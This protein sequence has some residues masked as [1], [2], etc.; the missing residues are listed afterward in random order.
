MKS[1]SSI[2]SGGAGEST[3]E[4]DKL[5][6]DLIKQ[7]QF[8]T[9]SIQNIKELLE[10]GANPNIK[11]P[12]VNTYTTI[13]NIIKT[14][15][16]PEI[17]KLL[18][19]YG[20]DANLQDT[21]GYNNGET[22]LHFVIGLKNLDLVKL[23]IKHHALINLQD[24]N[25]E[26]P[27]FKAVYRRAIDIVNYLLENNADVD[28]L[29]YSKIYIPT[30][31]ETYI[32]ALH[33]A[34]LHNLVEITKLLIQY[35]ADDNIG[36]DKHLTPLI[37]AIVRNNIEIV[38]ILLPHCT[39][40]NLVMGLEQAFHGRKLNMVKLLV[41]HENFDLIYDNQ[42]LLLDTMK[43]I[44]EQFL[45]TFSD[46][47]LE[48]I[49]WLISYIGKHPFEVLME[50]EQDVLTELMYIYSSDVKK[51]EFLIELGAKV[52]DIHPETGDTSLIVSAKNPYTNIEI[53]KCLL[54][55]VKGSKSTFINHE[56]NQGETALILFANYSDNIIKYLIENGGDIN[57]RNQYGET[58]FMYACKSSIDIEYLIKQGAKINNQ[59]LNGETP[60]IWS[61]KDEN[62]TNV[63]I[64][65]QNDAD[66][67]LETVEHKNAFQIALEVNNS[68]ILRLISEHIMENN[69]D[70]NN[71]YYKY[72][73]KY[74]SDNRFNWKD[75]CKLKDRY[76]IQKYKDLLHIE[77]SDV[78]DVCEQLDLYET[79]LSQI[80][81]NDIGKCVNSD[82]LDGNDVNDIY[83]ENFYVY[84]ENGTTY[85]EDIR[86]LFK[87]LKSFKKRQPPKQAENPYTGKPFS[88][89]IIKDIEEKYKIY[90]T[91][92]TGKQMDEVVTPVTPSSKDILLGQMSFF[93]NI[94]KQLSSK[95][96]FLN[97]QTDKLDSFIQE[98]KDIQV[99]GNVI[100]ND[101]ELQKLKNDDDLDKYKYQLIQLLLSKVLA[102][103]YKYVE[104]EQIIFPT[105]E[106]IQTVWNKVFKLN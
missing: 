99:Y 38:K 45:Q 27:L 56:N 89:D 53:V 48:I 102:D 35:D 51:I 13:T 14:K 57:Y 24:N 36:Y 54:N 62:D 26:T 22:L 60:L 95:E 63:R 72:V 34:S 76:E 18:L 103:K 9:P 80:K 33:I 78:D 42:E 4:Q 50:G 74:T 43:I 69:I 28:A 85:C 40:D 15:N 94:M 68:T 87:L 6:M 73:T 12:Y 100:F 47:D 98:L 92:S 23:L 8:D 20:L 79:K 81:Q 66:L 82:N 83:P 58:F 101:I 37:I 71:R 2:K 67:K 75:A 55:N 1:C 3:P 65:L 17:L 97:A 41:E 21:Q 46:Y 31:A 61:I 52:E 96:M 19:E 88:D 86:T 16:G 11:H 49:K 105:R 30:M 104:G 64:L 39:T 32:T 77:E 93:Y 91:I 59:S 70:I 84:Q 90:N 29:A 5:N 7:L 25:K 44:F 10:K 106:A